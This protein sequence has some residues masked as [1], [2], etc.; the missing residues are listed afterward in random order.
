MEMTVVE[1]LLKQLG[2]KKSKKCGGIRTAKQWGPYINV[3]K[4][5]KIKRNIGDLNL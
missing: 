4:V 1:E 5:A 2:R 3:A